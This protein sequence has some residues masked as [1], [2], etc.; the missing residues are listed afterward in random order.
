MLSEGYEIQLNAK[1]RQT[2]LQWI[3]GSEHTLYMLSVY[4]VVA[5][6]L[7]GSALVLINGVTLR[8]ARLILGWVTISG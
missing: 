1:I 5:A 2:L 4:E 3:A 8:W 7:S 6:W